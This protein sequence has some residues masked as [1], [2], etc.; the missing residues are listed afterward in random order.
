MWKPAVLLIPSLLFAE[1][2]ILTLR[3]AADLALKQ[4]PDLLMARLEEQKAEQAVRLAKD[5]FTPRIGVGSGLAYSSG[6]PLSIEGS[7]PSIIEARASQFLFN[8]QQSYLVAQ[9]RED[10]RGA[11]IASAARRDEVVFR[12]TSLFLDAERAGRLSDAARK[13]VENLDSVAQT[14]RQRVAEGRE[15]SIEAKRA[16]LNLALA[17]QRAQSLA[18]EQEF[19]ERS[20]ATVL[21]LGAEDRVEPAREERASPPLPSSDDAAAESAIKSSKE[22][23]RLESRLISTGIGLRAQRAARLPRV[24]LVAQY[25]LFAR[26]NNY[27][28]FFR[29]FQRHNGQLGVSFQLPI[30]PG[31]AVSAQTAQ[32]EAEAARLRLEMNATRNR[33]NLEARQAFQR[34]Q[35]AQMASEVSRLDLEVARDQVSINLALLQEGRAPLRQVEEARFQEN[36]KWI[37]FYDAQHKLEVARWDLLRHTGELVAV[38]R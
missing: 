19:A 31:P 20:L 32:S 17:R 4:N 7:A 35:A 33:I 2:H 30:M 12:T 6:F 3:Q 1:V 29:K 24:D 21:G 27:E 25:G 5:P 37:A 11:G 9:A 36:E 8:R 22:L 18:A 13:Q 23:R 28:D 34:V 26:F 14:V 10:A 16:A 15:L 38:L